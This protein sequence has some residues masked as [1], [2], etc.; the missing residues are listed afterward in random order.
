MH[1][2]DESAVTGRDGTTVRVRVLSD[3]GRTA[4]VQVEDCGIYLRQGQVH[5]VDSDQVR[6]RSY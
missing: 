6:R 1:V 4:R 3:D 2:I 5:T